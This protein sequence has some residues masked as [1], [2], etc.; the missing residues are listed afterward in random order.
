MN[1]VAQPYGKTLGLR[2]LCLTARLCLDNATA[3]VLGIPKYFLE[4]CVVETYDGLC[5]CAF[6]VGSL[7]CTLNNIS[8]RHHHTIIR[9]PTTHTR[10][11]ISACAVHTPW[12]QMSST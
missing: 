10:R 2:Y 3:M 11:L 4:A 7:T 5:P 9:P 1:V 8:L 12:I 6:P